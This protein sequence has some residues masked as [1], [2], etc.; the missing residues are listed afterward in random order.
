MSEQVRGEQGGLYILSERVSCG[1][2]GG[3]EKLG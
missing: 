1:S 3:V 2:E